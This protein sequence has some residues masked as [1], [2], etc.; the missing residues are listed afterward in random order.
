MYTHTY[1]IYIKWGRK[2]GWSGVCIYSFSSL[3]FFWRFSR[4]FSWFLS[5]LPPDNHGFGHRGRTIAEHHAASAG[6]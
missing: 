4:G 3:V 2:S 1:Y 5:A 6:K